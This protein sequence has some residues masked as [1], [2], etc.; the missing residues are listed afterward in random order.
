LIKDRVN[1]VLYKRDLRISDHEPLSA[2][3]RHGNVL[4]LYI[5]EPFLWSQPDSSRRHW[6]FIHDS[7]VELQENFLF[8]GTPLIVRTGDVVEVLQKLHENLGPFNLW[9]HE[10]T[11]N[12][13][14]FQRDISVRKWCVQNEIAWKEFSSNGVVRGLKSRD[15]WAQI[16]DRTMR[17]PMHE[18]P[19]ALTCSLAIETEAL[20]HKQSELFGDMNVGA[21]QPG[22]GSRR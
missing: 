16:R 22:V 21:V 7:L 11:G 8:L 2:A 5:I 19:E 3:A 20:P 4:P 12:A 10:E 6:C 1:I 14:T 13:W 15:Q 17:A 18:A 9:S